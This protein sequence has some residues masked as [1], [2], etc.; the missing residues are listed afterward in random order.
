M[1]GSPKLDEAIR[2]ATWI[3]LLAL[4]TMCMV[5]VYSLWR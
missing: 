3:V 1:T 4:V 5:G 2:I